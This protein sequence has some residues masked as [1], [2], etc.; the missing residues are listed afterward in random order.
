MG[1]D[2]VRHGCN[3]GRYDANRRGWVPVSRRLARDEPGANFESPILRCP[4]YRTM[5]F[6]FV[7]AASYRSPAHESAH[8]PAVGPRPMH[9][10]NPRASG[11]VWRPHQFLCVLKFSN[12]ERIVKCRSPVDQT[13]RPRCE[14][15]RG[16]CHRHG[17]SCISRRQRMARTAIHRPL[18]GRRPPTA[19][20]LRL[21]ARPRTT[22]AR[23]IRDRCAID[24]MATEFVLRLD[25]ANHRHPENLAA[26]HAKVREMLDLA[27]RAIGS[28]SKRSGELT[29]PTWDASRSTGG[30]AVIGSWEF[31]DD[32]KG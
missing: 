26:E 5:G 31:I 1:S 6:F 9:S 4:S 30:H 19:S 15:R 24:P 22:T 2:D 27:S 16:H 13:S 28:N 14:G 23:S 20:R 32:Q 18:V 11:R 7:P 17:R 21:S 25:L 12:L 29:T 10:T 8:F 3:R